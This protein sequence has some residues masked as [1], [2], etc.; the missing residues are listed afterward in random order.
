MLCIWTATILTSYAW[1]AD[2]S[3]TYDGFSYAWLDNK[4]EVLYRMTFVDPS[5][6]E[7]T[8]N[9]IFI[10]DKNLYIWPKPVVVNL[11]TGSKNEV[12]SWVY[13]HILWWIGNEINSKNITLIAWSGNK[14][15]QKND[16]AT[17]LWWEKNIVRNWKN[18][19]VSLI[20]IWWKNNVAD[21]QHD[22]VA[23]IWWYTN[24]IWQNNVGVFILWWEKNTV[25]KDRENIIV[26][27]KKVTVDTADNIFVYSNVDDGSQPQ[28]SNAFYLK[29]ENWVWINTEWKAGWLSVGW[30]VSVWEMNSSTFC[31]NDN[32]WLIVSYQWC[33]IWCTKAWVDNGQKWELLDKWDFC[34]EQYGDRFLTSTENDETI[35]KTYADAECTNNINTG[36]ATPCFSGALGSYKNVVFESTLIDST[37]SCPSEHSENK[38]VYK[39]NPWF[40][41]AW[42]DG[43]KR[44]H[45]D[46]AYEWKDW[47]IE[48][49]YSGQQISWYSL[50]PVSCSSDSYTTGTP[51]PDTCGNHGK[52]LICLS[53]TMY[54][55][56]GSSL[57]GGG[58]ATNKLYYKNCAVTGYTCNTWVYNLSYD[59]VKSNDATPSNVS[60]RKTMTL[61]RW[62]YRLCL[63]YHTI[64]GNSQCK[65]D[66]NTEKHYQLINCNTGYSTWVSNPYVCKK[67]CTI[68]NTSGSPV[69]YKHATSITGYVSTWAT[70]TGTCAGI[71]LV[72]NDGDWR[73]STLNWA[74]TTG[75]QYNNCALKSKVCSSIYNVSGTTYNQ[76]SGTSIYES[77]EAYSASWNNCIH[78]ST[79]YRLVGC[80]SGYNADGDHC[81]EDPVCNPTYNGETLADLTTSK[82]LCSKWSQMEFKYNEDIYKWTWKCKNW[83]KTVNC[84]ATKDAECKWDAPTNAKFVEW[85]DKNLDKSYQRMAYP[86]SD[87]Y[88]DKG[89]YKWTVKCAYE[90]N[91][92]YVPYDWKCYKCA[93]WT[94]DPNSDRCT[95]DVECKEGYV[96]DQD[97]FECKRSWNCKLSD[98]TIYNKMPSNHVQYSWADVVPIWMNDK[99]WK[100]YDE[101]DDHEVNLNSCEYSCEPG[102]YCFRGQ[103]SGAPSNYDR[104]ACNKPYCLRHW[105][106]D[107]GY[108]IRWWTPSL[109]HVNNLGRE[110]P[111]FASDVN[112][113]SDFD[114]YVASHPGHC[115]YRCPEE[116][117]YTA[118]YGSIYCYSEEKAAQMRRNDEHLGICKTEYHFWYKYENK[119]SPSSK[120]TPWTQYFTKSEVDKND[121]AW[122]CTNGSIA[123]KWGYA[124]SY[125]GYSARSDS[126]DAYYC[127][128]ECWS[129]EYASSSGCTKCPTGTIPDQSK[130]KEIN[131]VKL[132]LRCKEIECPNWFWLGTDGKTCVSN[133]YTLSCPDWVNGVV[134]GGKCITCLD[135]SKTIT[136][137]GECI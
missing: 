86:K 27:W 109:S 106:W 92:Q 30:A 120:N 25:K 6:F 45:A 59:S 137:S 112:Q 126:S 33:L 107:N 119:W 87:I 131:W 40:H 75:Y 79:T 15:Y 98:G 39:C 61:T 101:R 70:C 83:N 111:N 78:T 103:P 62:Q 10:E 114:S 4:T 100:C 116:N 26:W 135:P 94:W 13:A 117:R 133:S 93:A 123:Y 16:N 19:W 65:S 104:I 96:W 37:G 134:I 64:N 56:S 102:Y 20:S 24:K 48:W 72:C 122:M 127:Y 51:H 34:K 82:K 125:D 128:K 44:C 54:V 69:S 29:L 18:N 77:C 36:Y 99:Y 53:W 89:H 108:Y 28:S 32:L 46:C 8:V 3:Y 22:G 12:A 58:V 49:F 50:N 130:Y 42:S 132:Y 66:Q 1:A 136:E 52:T 115:R 84:S 74:I 38:C 90:C 81:V 97:E 63:D 121:C 47:I 73:K 105:E 21:T 2:N 7:K 41:L 5:D 80:N 14:V 95:V 85:S 118:S 43:N 31:T 88:D 110:S 113:A 17:I 71:K 129:D 68:K 9:E 11:F 60:D 91:D 76:R 57:T 124:S 35:N 23:L 55:S 67:D